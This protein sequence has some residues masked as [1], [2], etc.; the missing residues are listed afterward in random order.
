MRAMARRSVGRSPIRAAQA[1]TDPGR[2]A[3]G[4]MSRERRHPLAC[5]CVEAPGPA[6][7]AVVGHM[8]R[9]RGGGDADGDA[10]VAHPPVEQRLRPGAQTVL[11]EEGELARGRG[12]AG[13]RPLAEGAHEDDAGAAGG[14]EREQ[15]GLDLAL[16]GIER[17]LDGGDAAVLEVR[18]ISAKAEAL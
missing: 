9:V 5:R 1:R 13:E 18:A 2:R 15:M 8:D 10:R 14:G 3:S 17:H 11:R 4:I 6:H 12:P 7:R 16:V